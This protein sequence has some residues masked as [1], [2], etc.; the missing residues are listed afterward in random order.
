M[1]RKNERP[2][3]E[4]VKELLH[5]DRETGIFTRRKPSRS[6]PK[7]RKYGRVGAGRVSELGYVMIMIDG[8]NYN[9]GILAWVYETGEWPKR[10]KYFNGDGL[11]N[12]FDNLRVLDVPRE[13]IQA[14]P[15]THE[16]LCE[17][18][19]YE[20]DTGVFTWRMAS[21]VARPGDRAGGG[22][23]LGYRAIGLD[24]KKYLEHVLAWFYMTGTWPTAD[25]DHKN[26]DKQDNRWANL[27]LATRS[28]NGHNKLPQ[29]RNK[30]GVKGVNRH[31]NKFRARI[32]VGGQY[33]DLGVFST[34][35]AATAAR[36]DAEDKMV[37]EFNRQK[38][39]DEIISA[40]YAM[41]EINGPEVTDAAPTK[42]GGH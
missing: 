5:Y 35:E 41:S 12:R 31:G 23:S 37:G 11:D 4:R 18:L 9:A 20:P 3:Q 42:Y 27:R 30:T 36:R 17:L 16:R 6:G 14:R 7:D 38:P 13:E 19:H 39:V 28:Q 26:A 2:T 33:I 15:L 22:H 24:Y 32:N 25:V 34:L 10:I 1:K 21:S 40:M 8:I 29:R